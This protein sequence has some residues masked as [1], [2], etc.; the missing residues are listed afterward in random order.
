M[1]KDNLKQ[2][3]EIHSNHSF[4]KILENPMQGSISDRLQGAI[5]TESVNVPPVQA[6][7][8]PTTIYSSVN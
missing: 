3:G 8:P 1:K 5:T 4:G 6:Y 2:S 7:Q